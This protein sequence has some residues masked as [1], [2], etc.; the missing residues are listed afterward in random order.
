[1]P[2]RWEPPP[3]SIPAETTRMP[4]AEV[5]P[6]AYLPPPVASAP[7]ASWYPD[8][9]SPGLMR[10]W[11]GARWTEHRAAAA[12]AP[13]ASAVVYNNVSVRGGGSSL[14]GLHIVLTLITC[15]AWLPIWLLIE[16]IGAAT[17]K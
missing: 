11:D 9:A 5:Y 15:G 12:V 10:Y 1:M 8:P 17:R 7:A 4:Q 16:I 14:V 13:Q 6:N 3:L 2:D